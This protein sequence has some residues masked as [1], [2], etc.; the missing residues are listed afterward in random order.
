M[1][2]DRVLWYGIEVLKYLW[3]ICGIL[4]LVCKSRGG[5][6]VGISLS[7]FVVSLVI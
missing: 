7:V 5:S 4:W 1:Y 6:F 3:F 2:L